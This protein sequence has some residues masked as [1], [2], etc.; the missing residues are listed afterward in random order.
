MKNPVLIINEY[1]A[2][3][4]NSTNQLIRE[5]VTTWLTKELRK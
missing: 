2:P 5:T 1:Y 4:G 3:T